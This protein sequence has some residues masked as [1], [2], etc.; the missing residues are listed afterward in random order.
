MSKLVWD[1]TGERYYH[2]GVKHGVLYP[3]DA[4]GAYP[5][6]VAWNGLT[7]V[8]ENPEG[9]EPN[10][11]WADNMKYATI[12]S[13][14][15]FGFKISAYMW[16]DEFEECDGTREPVTG[17]H[18]G[19]QT[20]KPF[21]FCYRT[22]KG[23]D[24]ASEGDDGYIL[25]LIYGAIASPADKSYETINDNPDAIEFEWDCKTTPIDIGRINGVDYKPTAKID[26][27][28]SVVGATKMALLEAELYGDTNKTAHLP[29]PAA[30]IT[31][32][33]A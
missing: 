16:P 24:T 4:T 31:L 19:Q 30:I 28:S 32:L 1:A 3:Q 22:E 26:I 13:A 27:D 9:G 8:D 15:D 10:D 21:G 5:T 6:G 18:I 2:A 11:L 29:L 14:E 25:H 33:S 17:V 20:R 23:N 12:V 7:G